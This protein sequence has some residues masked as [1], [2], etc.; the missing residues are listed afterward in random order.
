MFDDRRILRLAVRLRTAITENAVTHHRNQLPILIRGLQREWDSLTRNLKSVVMAAGMGWHEASRSVLADGRFNR[1]EV[2][3]RVKELCDVSENLLS[4]S[5][6]WT[7]VPAIYDDLKELDEHFPVLK[8]DCNALW[9]K[10]EPITLDDIY[11]GAFEIRLPIRVLGRMGNSDDFRVIALDRH[12]SEKR[13]DVVHPHVEGTHLCTGEATD[14]IAL[15]LKQGRILDF[16]QLVDGILHTYNED[17]PYV[18][19]DQWDG[20]SSIECWDCGY[21]VD[22]GDSFYCEQC[23]R[24]FCDSCMSCCSSC[25]NSRC[26]TCLV[27]CPCCEE[28][29][30]RSCMKP[31]PECGEAT[32]IPCLTT[33][34]PD[35]RCPECRSSD[36]GDSNEN[37]P[38]PVSATAGAIEACATVATG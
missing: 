19:L 16:F 3:N 38:S 6:C 24:E 8:W 4:P 31:C 10:T 26:R 15:A 27:E 18:R 35:G 25:S 20:G 7:T 29:C 37:T 28:S 5:S 30:C 2:L 13:E 33:T 34:N 23:S 36:E 22:D 21:E 32:C 12:P 17:S 11:L 14:S 1:E 9:V